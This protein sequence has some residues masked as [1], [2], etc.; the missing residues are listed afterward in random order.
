MSAVVPA[1]R[2]LPTRGFRNTPSSEADE[3]FPDEIMVRDPQHP[4]HGRSF[5]VVGQTSHRGGNFSE[6]RAG[7]T[8]WQ[9]TTTAAAKTSA[10]SPT[11]ASPA[12]ASRGNWTRWCVFMA[13]PRASSP[14]TSYVGK[15]SPLEASGHGASERLEPLKMFAVPSLLHLLC[16]NRVLRCALAA[17]PEAR[18]TGDP[19]RG[20]L[21]H[22]VGHY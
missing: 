1:S 9:R 10:R 5:R 14:T 20:L 2:C 17:G 16:V 7:S 12:T 21:H 22:S 4:L 8:S 11:P 19:A 6:R 13:S 15:E 18:W 3:S